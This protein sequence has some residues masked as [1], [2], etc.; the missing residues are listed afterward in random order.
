M[1]ASGKRLFW[2]TAMTKTPDREMT[3]PSTSRAVIGSFSRMMPKMTQ[4]RLDSQ[5]Q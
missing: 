3:E 4:L 2:R 5:V 1:D